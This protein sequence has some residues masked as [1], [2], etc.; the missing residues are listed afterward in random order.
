MVARVIGLLW[1]LERVGKLEAAILIWKRCRVI[2]RQKSFVDLGPF[3]VAAQ[4][5]ELAEFAH[6]GDLAVLGE[7][8]IDGEN[9]LA[10]LSRYE[11]ATQR[12]LLR[13]LHELQRLQAARKGER[14]PPPQA[15]DIDVTGLP[16]S[17]EL[18]GQPPAEQI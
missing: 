18:E 13:V 4:A 16:E 1:R 6:A 17:S 9:S 5:R 2:A 15:V 11:S 7:A 3:D 12:N 8:Y 10:K 14:V